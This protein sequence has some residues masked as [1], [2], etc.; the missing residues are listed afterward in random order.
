MADENIGAIDSFV[1]RT[2]WVSDKEF[3]LKQLNEIYEAYKKLGEIKIS[4]NNVQ[5]LAGIAPLAK[6]AAAEIDKISKANTSLTES[7]KKTYEGLN[8]Y[9][10]AFHNLNSS[11]D[12][13]I[14]KQVEYRQRLSQITAEL[15]T[16]KAQQDLLANTP[17]NDEAK[18]QINDRIQALS[19]EQAEVKLLNQQLSK[20][21]NNQIKGTQAI[22]GTLDQM[23]AQLNEV[24][25]LRDFKLQVGSEEYE[26]AQKRVL[27]LNDAIK[28][29]EFGG[30]D[31]QR[32]VG[33]YHGAAK[34]IVDALSDVEQKIDA[35]K[36]KQNG[37]QDLSKRNPIGF[38]TGGQKAELDQTSAQIQN[39]TAQYES[40]N[41]ITSNPQFLNVSKFADGRK[42]IGF[43]V[44]QLN[45]L[46]DAG[47]KDTK[48]YKDLQARIASLTDQL[49][50]TRAEITALASDTRS[51]DLVAG[52]ITFAA[53]VFQTAAGAAVLFGAS[54]ED[55]AQATKVLTAVQAVSNGVKGIANELTT[56]GTAANKVYAFVQGLVATS[57]D[58]TAAAAT[59]A[60]AA[61]GI[62]GLVVSV[63]GLVVFAMSAL[64]K[65]LTE[66]GEKRKIF[67]DI[68]K[69]A[70]EG[71]G[72][73]VTRLEVLKKVILDTTLSIDKRKTAVWEYNKIAD[74]SNQID[75]KSIDN[76][77]LI[78]AAINRQIEL[79]KKRGL[80]RAAETVIA[81][82]AEALFLKQLELEDRFP[83]FGDKAVQSIEKRAQAT[84]DAQAKLKGLKGV[85]ASELLAFVD[86]PDD[87]LQVIANKSK[88]VSLLLDT[89]TK[90]ILLSLKNQQKQI[91][92]SRQN[93]TGGKAGLAVL[94]DDIENATKDLDAATKVGLEFIGEVG[95]QVTAPTAGKDD[96]KDEDAKKA[97]LDLFKLRQ[98]LIIDENKKIA[99]ADIFY[100]NTRIAALQKAAEAEKAILT[101]QATFDLSKKGILKDEKLKIDKEYSEG[102]IK[103]EDELKSKSALLLVGEKEDFN[104]VMEAQLAEL[105]AISARLNAEQFAREQ[106]QI[107]NLKE[108]L[109][110]RLNV[111]QISSD[112]ELTSL[113]NRYAKGLVS[114]KEYEEEK[115]RI[116]AAAT[117]D[118]LVAQIEYHEKLL[119]LPSVTG[120]ET[121][122]ALAALAKLKKELSGLNLDDTTSKFQKSAKEIESFLTNALDYYNKITSIV[123]G[124]L[125]AS[126][127]AQ[128]NRIQEEIDL[129]DEKTKK[130]I[131]AINQTTANKT[132][133]ASKIA[134]VEARAAAQKR[135]L[136]RQQRDI[137]IRRA[138][139]D[140]AANIGR[141]AIEGALAVVHQ[142]GTGDPFTAIPRAIVAGALAAAQ[143]AV[144]IA[145][146]IPKFRTGKTKENTYEGLGIVGDGGRSELIE[147][148]DG[149]MEVTG[150]TPEITWVGKND[151]IHPDA[152][153]ALK[154]AMKQTDRMVSGQ[155]TVKAEVNLDRV[156]NEI[157]GMKNAVVSAIR[158]KQETHIRIEGPVSRWMKTGLS[159]EEF[160]NRY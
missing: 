88:K 67:N 38:Q 83:E 156:T 95:G 135:T 145:T 1:D 73:E 32:Q 140:K 155:T 8:N 144:A 53:D 27:A 125:D 41:T 100:A 34:I 122:K 132:D 91:A 29:E 159:W 109:E 102:K 21:T 152:D 127:T 119:K 45:N 106:K 101:A 146:P 147:R 60:K 87:Q 113:N 10:G 129:L 62:L 24:R 63:V 12:E 90:N 59:R 70:I 69:K 57:L 52:S 99:E 137:D 68:Q 26:L 108:N 7:T 55:A 110:Q 9:N 66:A 111:I 128:K 112:N 120:P 149:S 104:K 5:G 80:A 71:Y 36:V 130:E 46:E 31:F 157:K 138:Q 124:A 20:I 79:I 103:I 65:T 22:T 94:V 23:R 16:L 11:I 3:V 78:E 44:K 96:K 72:A 158:S 85:K 126:A 49:A 97:A 61:L 115:K 15:K 54:E 133:A 75:A 64:N 58:R 28:K 74:K 121:E 33:N 42:E 4:L 93:V 143:L 35:L 150:N 39:L 134:I 81:E 116:T 56:K 105:D 47:L 123:G 114:T 136:E 18:K 151:I 2:G 19:K 77:A 40:L 82:K 117:R 153:L 37:L 50:D 131:D 92:D 43:F 160:K 89:S 98:Q 17:G 76:S 86:L 14:K 6:E 13:N 84:I 139:F 141:I 148:A 48:V 51:F 142:L 30:G 107:D 118:T 25:N 154:S